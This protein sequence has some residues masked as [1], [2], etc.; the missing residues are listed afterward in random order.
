[1]SRFEKKNQGGRDRSASYDR[2]D[3][4][5]YQKKDD[6]RYEDEEDDYRQVQRGGK[7]RNNYKDDN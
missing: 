5:R 4:G 6:R 1:M 3:E 2:K 7:G